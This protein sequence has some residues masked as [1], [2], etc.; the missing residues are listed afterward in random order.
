MKHTDPQPAP[1]GLAFAL[2]GIILLAVAAL[3]VV[4][5]AALLLRITG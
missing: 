4:G 2:A 3:A 5:L 1:G